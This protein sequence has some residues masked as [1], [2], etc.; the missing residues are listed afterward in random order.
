MPETSKADGFRELG[1]ARYPLK[2]NWGYSSQTSKS[3]KC[4]RVKSHY[5]ADLAEFSTGHFWVIEKHVLKKRKSRG[6]WSPVLVEGTQFAKNL[7][8][9]HTTRSRMWDTACREA[10]GR[11]LQGLSWDMCVRLCVSVSLC[12]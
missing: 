11:P 1:V 4:I 9:L 5:F 3:Q 10:W 12:V 7:L 2:L 6:A 8:I